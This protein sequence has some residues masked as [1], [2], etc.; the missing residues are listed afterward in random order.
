MILTVTLHAALDRVIF[1][2]EFTPGARMLASQSA[3]Y[4]GGKGFDASV[5]LAGMGVPSLAMGILAGE[6]GR[7]LEFLLRGYGIEVNL[8][9]VEGETRVAYVIVESEQYTHSHL[10]TPGYTVTPEDLQVFLSRYR[11]RTWEADW[12]IAAGSLPPGAPDDLYAQVIEIAH[13]AGSKTLIDSTGEALLRSFAQQPDIVKQS[14]FEFC[15]TFAI[16][17]E[18]VQSQEALLRQV[19][20]VRETYR[21]PAMV[22]TRGEQGILAATPEADYTAACPAQPAVNAAGAG[23]CVSAALAWRLS[24]SDPW[25]EALRWAA[26]AGTAGVLT[27]GTGEL[28]MDDVLHFISMAEVN[29]L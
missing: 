8:T 26:A 18:N 13:Q 21:L 7:Q 17:P 3:V 28:H 22:I 10:I 20:Q 1:V 12:V 9:W 2:P 4:V 25:P 11:S 5:A 23:D 29:R 24:L 14:A 27:A 19:R 15:S 6:N 16:R